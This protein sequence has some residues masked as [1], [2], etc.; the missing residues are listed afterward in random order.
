MY[1]KNLSSV[2]NLTR[3][4]VKINSENPNSTELE[5]QLYLVQ[6]LSD[7]GFQIEIIEYA[8]DRNNIIALY[9]PLSKAKS[10]YYKYIGRWVMKE[11]LTFEDGVLVCKYIYQSA[12][13][14][15]INSHG[16]SG[17]RARALVSASQVQ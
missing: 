2:I 4:L 14:I 9:P 10:F 11:E 17:I 15:R 6:Y 5:V 1:S 7:L 3:D 8:K 16:G 13:G 12:I